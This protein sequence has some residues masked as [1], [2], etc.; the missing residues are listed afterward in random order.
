MPILRRGTSLATFVEVAHYVGLE[1]VRMPAPSRYVPLE[2]AQ[3]GSSNLFGGALPMTA[4]TR[5]Q[6]LTKT[7][8]K[9]KLTRLSSAICLIDSPLTGF[10]YGQLAE[11]RGFKLL[12]GGFLCRVVAYPLPTGY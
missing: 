9:G 8:R 5:A 1:G 3:A 10:T 12:S 6:G 4:L 2:L 11:L 7:A